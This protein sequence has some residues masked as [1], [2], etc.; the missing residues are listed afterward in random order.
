VR[1]Y[2]IRLPCFHDFVENWV[3]VK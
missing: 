2:W 3:I 1:L